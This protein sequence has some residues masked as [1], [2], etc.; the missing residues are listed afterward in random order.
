MNSIVPCDIL[1]SNGRLRR[2]PPP[3]VGFPG[4]AQA[5]VDS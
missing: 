5:L 3:L 2:T 1:K 4:T